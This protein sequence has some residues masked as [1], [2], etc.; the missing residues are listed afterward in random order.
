MHD[1]LP[2][3]FRLTLRDDSLAPG[4]RQGDYAEFQRDLVELVATGDWVLIRASD[5]LHHLREFISLGAEGWVGAPVNKSGAYH[6]ITSQSG[7]SIEA[8]YI[9]GGVVGRKSQ[10]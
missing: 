4:L 7:A 10:R 1:H 6:A 9:A 8:I 2:N 5:G 3:V